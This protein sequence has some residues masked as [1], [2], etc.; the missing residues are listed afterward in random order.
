MTAI[1]NQLDEVAAAGR[2]RITL[3][4]LAGVALASFA[5]LLLE[6]ALTRLF[7]VILFYHFAFL[8]ISLALLGLGAGG[9]FAHLGR[10]RLG[11]YDTR[12]L[13]AGCC[14]ANAVATLAVLEIVLH[15]PVSLELSGANFLKLTVIYL[16]SAIPFFFTGLLFSAVFAREARHIPLLY[17]ADLAGGALACLAIVPLLDLLGGPNAVLFA[18]VAMALASAVWALSPRGRNLAW[19][20]AGSLILLV[21][22]NRIWDVVDVVYAKGVRLDSVAKVEFVRWNAISRIEV[23]RKADQSKWVVIDADAN[24]ALVNVDPN[25]WQGEWKRGLMSAPPSVANILRPRGDYAIIGPGGGVDVVRAVANGST[26]VTGIE[27]NSIIADTVMRG[28]YAA[29]TFGLYNLPQVHIV[30][31]DGRSFIRSSRDRYDVVEMTLVDTWAS[32]AAGAFALSESNL[33]TTEAFE[34]YFRHLR[35]DGLVAVTRWEFARP[36]EALRVVSVALEALQ[37]LGVHDPARNFMVI[38]DGPLDEDGRAVIVLAKKS[39]FTGEEEQRVRSHLDQ[40]PNLRA[41]YM[42]SAPGNNPFSQLIASRD[43]AAFARTYPYNVAPVT[44]DAPFFFF[45]LRTGQVLRSAALAHRGMDWKVSLGVVV[46]GMVLVISVA[47]VLA[48]L[49]LPLALGARPRPGTLPRLIY[50]VAIG[51]GYILVEITFVQR[52]VL[53]LGHPTY[54]ITVVIFLLLLAS[55]AGS[56]ISRRWQ[57]QQWSLQLPLA[58]IV[59]AL[60]VY[61]FALPGLLASGVGLPFGVKLLVSAAILVPLGLVMGMPFPTGLRALAQTVPERHGGGPAPAPVTPSESGSGDSAVEWAWALNA[62]SSVLGSVGAILIAVNFGLRITLAASVVAYLAAWAL[63]G[64]W[65]PGAVG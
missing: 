58:A 27:I 35:D 55:G 40:N 36:R 22:A 24:T 39:T 15:I 62:A 10:G 45:T 64:T 8:A 48:L 57:A 20:V 2:A 30:V 54:A 19:A 25:A 11:R 32:T 9:V 18:G 17:G 31:S 61:T 23:D 34:E 51:L 53:F 63:A 28:R 50:F 52:F 60:S 41:V 26:N 42:P 33:Y 1:V 16:A 46:L 47:A 7:S 38:S 43:P 13:G 49:V 14:L 5:A 12:T 6:L 65:R 29:Y 56:L 3:R 21:A 44:D 59:V 37:R 4:P